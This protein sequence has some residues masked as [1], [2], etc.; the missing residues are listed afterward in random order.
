MSFCGAPKF[1]KSAVNLICVLLIKRKEIDKVLQQINCETKV[2]LI[3]LRR[4]AVKTKF[5]TK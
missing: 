4:L 1:V 2:R 3:T 5:L